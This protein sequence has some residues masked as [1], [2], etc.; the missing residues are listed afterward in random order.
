M[1]KNTLIY[2]S[3]LVS[4]YIVYCIDTNLLRMSTLYCFC[5][6]RIWNREK[7]MI[8]RWLSV[9]MNSHNDWFGIHIIRLLYLYLE[10]EWPLIYIFYCHSFVWTHQHGVGFFSHSFI[11]TPGHIKMYLLFTSSSNL[12]IFI[13]SLRIY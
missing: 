13:L 7:Q 10:V 6:I 2:V 5:R 12:A 4:L 1:M 9:L 11:Y 8:F 3:R